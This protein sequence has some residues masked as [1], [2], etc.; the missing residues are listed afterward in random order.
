MKNA[1]NIDRYIAMAEENFSGANGYQ[2]PN[3]AN[4][5]LSFEG[6]FGADGDY[7]DADG[8][9]MDADGYYDADG[10]YMDADGDYSYAAATPRSGHTWRPAPSRPMAAPAQRRVAAKQPTPYQVNVS[11]TTAGTL[12]VVLFGLNTYLLDPNFGSSTGVT[13]TPA[14]VSVTYLELLNQSASQPF[15]TSLI[16]I[17]TSTAS[18]L[19]QI[20]TVVSKD[21]NGQLC[22]IPVITQSY[23]S[24]NQ[25][26]STILDVPYPVKIDGNTYVTFPILGNTTATYTFFPAEKINT[27]R[28]L[29]GGSE[30][31]QYSAPAV[32]VAV[33]M[34]SARPVGM[35]PRPKMIRAG[36][37]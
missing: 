11:N 12:T 25:F 6:E 37:R 30:L 29:G 1:M 28:V 36:R 15:E 3:L 23:F 7:Y 5:D 9:Y 14:Q 31:Q 18:Q 22:Q 33:P 10:D 34:F 2:D 24:A 13:V 26:Q 32:P 17:Q 21:A 20:L 19:T 35:K 27:S 8:D 4:L 16:R